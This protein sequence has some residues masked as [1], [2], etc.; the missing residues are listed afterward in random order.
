MHAGV[1]PAVRAGAEVMK[2]W[3]AAF[4]EEK[5]EEEE[6]ETEM[7][8]ED[9]LWTAVEKVLGVLAGRWD[10]MSDED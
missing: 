9:V 5:E 10:D 2:V 7:L 3:D 1:G 8:G 4:G 6:E